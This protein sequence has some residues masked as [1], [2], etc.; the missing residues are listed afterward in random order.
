[1]STS[2]PQSSTSGRPEY[3]RCSEIPSR[4]K[5][6]QRLHHRSLPKKCI[7]TISENLEEN[8]VLNME[9]N[10]I[11]IDRAGWMRTCNQI[12]PIFSRYYR[13]VVDGSTTG[14]KAFNTDLQL[15]YTCINYMEIGHYDFHDF[16]KRSTNTDVTPND[17]YTDGAIVG[18]LGIHQPLL[19]KYDFHDSYF[20]MVFY[21]RVEE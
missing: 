12:Q 11:T 17:I 16:N 15:G 1:M 7:S 2:S 13:W 18:M 19:Q 6:R 5:D 3:S 14:G 4:G 20:R 21:Y 10:I 8:C 9:T